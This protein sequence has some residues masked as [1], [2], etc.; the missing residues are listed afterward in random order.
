METNTNGQEFALYD[1]FL[2]GT[3]YFLVL[4]RTD[5]TVKFY[6]NG[7]YISSMTI[8]GSDNLSL[9]QIG[10]K[11]RSFKGTIDELGIWNRALTD[12]DVSRLYNS[13]SGLSYPFSAQV[14]SATSQSFAEEDVIPV[15]ETANPDKAIVKSMDPATDVFFYPNP[16]GENLYFR[17]IRSANARV[18]IYDMHGQ[19]VL[20]QMVANNSVDISPL[21][22]GIYLVKLE[23]DGKTLTHKLM[24]E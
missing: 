24:K 15:S 1:R 9:S 11:G 2:T 22:K 16:A 5:N 12:A 21:A 10:F 20:T 23:N 6:R 4:T 7:K 3:W 17:N 14:L 19:M 13:G 18:S 8:S